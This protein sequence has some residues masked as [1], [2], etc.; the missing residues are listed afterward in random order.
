[1]A[2]ATKRAMVRKRA[3]AL[4]RHRRRTV[5]L[6]VTCSPSSSDSRP[7]SA[8]SWAPPVEGGGSDGDGDKEGDGEKEGEGTHLS[9]S[10]E[11]SP[12]SSHAPSPPQTRDRLL[13]RRGRR[14]ASLLR[15]L[16]HRRLRL[17]RGL[18]ALSDIRQSY[19][20]SFYRMGAVF[21]AFIA[22]DIAFITFVACDRIY[23][24]RYRICHIYHM[25]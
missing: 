6:L 22:C 12:S 18:A 10:S 23:R 3:R 5:S 25:R 9:S 21:I 4:I 17:R 24:M 20:T 16:F 1:M 7:P 13:R 11:P 8:P 19:L 15:R 14:P 2:T